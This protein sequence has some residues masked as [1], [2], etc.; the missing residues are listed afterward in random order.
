[1]EF[2][3]SIRTKKLFFL[4]R[5]NRKLNQF[6][7]ESRTHEKRRFESMFKIYINSSFQWKEQTHV[8]RHGPGCASKD[9]QAI[10]EAKFSAENRQGRGGKYKVRRFWQKEEKTLQTRAPSSCRCEKT[11]RREKERNMIQIEGKFCEWRAEEKKKKTKRESEKK[12]CMLCAAVEERKESFS[13]SEK[14]SIMNWILWNILNIVP[15]FFSTSSAP[16]L[17]AIHVELNYVQSSSKEYRFKCFLCGKKAQSEI[18]RIIAVLLVIILLTFASRP[19]QPIDT[20][21]AIFFFLDQHCHRLLSFP[22]LLL[23]AF[24]PHLNKNVLPASDARRH[25]RL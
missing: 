22:S 21:W 6:R 9:F 13:E 20:S 15:T 25:S 16:K 14:K 4:A 7:K 23:S 10:F 12:S 5:V 11:A 24:P 8:H 3:D 2:T 18:G 1:M 19:L 17:S